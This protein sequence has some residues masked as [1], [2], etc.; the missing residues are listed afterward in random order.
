MKAADPQQLPTIVLFTRGSARLQSVYKAGLKRQVQ[1]AQAFQQK[2]S[3]VLR[4]HANLRSNEISAVRLSEARA[5]AVAKWL[6]QQGV[7]KRH[8]KI[9]GTG[10][11]QSWDVKMG[12]KTPLKWNR[13]VE[14]SIGVAVPAVPQ[15]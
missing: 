8:V 7:N 6:Y 1:Y 14:I 9:L 13:R 11:A 2:V 10:S 4:G 12:G 5:G 15:K 3:Y